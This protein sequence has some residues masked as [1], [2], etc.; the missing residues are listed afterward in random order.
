MPA[1]K[2]AKRPAGVPGAQILGQNLY[3]KEDDGVLWIGFDPNETIGTSKTR[4]DEKGNT[5][6]GNPMVATSRGFLSV[7]GIGCTVAL[8]SINVMAD[9]D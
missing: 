9:T 7:S 4:V 1:N 8:V 5:R 2:T 6:G 3:L